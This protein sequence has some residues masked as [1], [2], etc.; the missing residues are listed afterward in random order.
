MGA[1]QRADSSRR[2]VQPMRAENFGDCGEVGGANLNHGAEF[3][4]EEC[5]ESVRHADVL[6]IPRLDGRGYGEIKIDAGMAGERHF[7]GGGEQASVGA[8]VIREELLLASEL[9]DG[10]PKILQ[11]VWSIHVRWS[12]SHL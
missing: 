6:G 4:V 2:G 12:F 9:L 8:I 11:V 10:I 5:G 3:F 1:I 7:H